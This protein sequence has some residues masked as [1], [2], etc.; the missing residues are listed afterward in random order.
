MPSILRCG[1]QLRSDVAPDRIGSALPLGWE[2][3]MS[4]FPLVMVAPGAASHDFGAF[5]RKS[6]M[7]AFASM[8]E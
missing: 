7:L 4:V 1:A 2:I 6:G 3:P 5:Q 8:T